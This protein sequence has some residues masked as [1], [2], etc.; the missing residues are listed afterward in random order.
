MGLEYFD[1]DRVREICDKAI[2]AGLY[3]ERKF[4]LKGIK[5]QF[6]ATLPIEDSPSD[7]LKSDFHEMNDTEI[8]TGDSVVPLQRWLHNAAYKLDNK[9]KSKKYFLELENEV[10]KKLAGD[11]FNTDYGQERVVHID[12]LVPFRYISDAQKAGQSVAHLTVPQFIDREPGLSAVDGTPQKGYGTGW[13]IGEQHLITNYHVIN[14]RGPGEGH[15]SRDDLLAQVKQL[16]IRFDFDDRSTVAKAINP[17]RLCAENIQ[18]DYA[19]LEINGINRPPLPLVGRELPLTRDIRIP[20]NIIQH[21]EGGP[22][23]IGFRNNLTADA[24][25]Y[26]IGYFTDTKGGSSGS[27]VCN[28]AWQVIALHKAW[29]ERLG[30]LNY[31][32]KD[33]AW[34]NYGT[35][36]NVIIDDLKE[37]HAELWAAIGAKV[38]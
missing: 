23:Q 21:P 2:K 13:L 35:R 31:Q 27:P 18:L 33:T 30:I 11:Q 20:V 22:K 5:R 7:Q 8:D 15:A 17:V 28:D 34:I 38:V 12:D 1:I 10:A 9:P 3:S 14:A 32:G 37:N 25:T 16:E 24:D 26:N 6:I 36:M 4:L 19:I 29:T